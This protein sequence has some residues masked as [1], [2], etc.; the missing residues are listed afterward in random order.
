MPRKKVA[1]YD[2]TQDVFA[3]RLT[4]VMESHGITQAKLSDMVRERGGVLQRQTV[5]MYMNGQSKPDTERLT[6]ICKVLNVSADYLLGLSD[7]EM[8]DLKIQALCRM[9]GLSGEAADNLLQFNHPDHDVTPAVNVVLSNQAEPGKLFLA[10]L[11]LMD[12]RDH[13]HDYLERGQF[14]ENHWQRS[15]DIEKKYIERLEL[16]FYRA[17]KAFRSAIDKAIGYQQLMDDLEAAK[18]ED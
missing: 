6:M 7:A 11:G 15:W 14:P 1:T 13:A 16:S 8:P 5:S 18:R 3:V 4:G 2:A 10:V 12:E 17:E 9:T